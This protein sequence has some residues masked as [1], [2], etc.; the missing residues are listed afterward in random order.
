MTNGTAGEREKLLIEALGRHAIVVAWPIH[1]PGMTE[2]EYSCYECEAIVR[3]D[4]SG[5]EDDC[6]L[7]GYVITLEPPAS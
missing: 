3:A 4:G 1:N 5:H 7:S 6:L 2:P